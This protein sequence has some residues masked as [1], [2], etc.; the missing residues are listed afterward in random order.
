[1][2]VRDGTLITKR[3]F[4]ESLVEVVIN[5]GLLYVVLNNSSREKTVKVT[6][7]TV[8]VPGT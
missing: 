1:M 6:V 4:K 2:S 3:I 5:R 8:S 7:Q